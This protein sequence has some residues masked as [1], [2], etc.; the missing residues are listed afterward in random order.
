ML[1]EKQRKTKQTQR[2][3]PTREQSREPVTGANKRIMA[4]NRKLLGKHY[5]NKYRIG[6]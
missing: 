2:P 1:K 4:Q 3:K 6:A 5:A